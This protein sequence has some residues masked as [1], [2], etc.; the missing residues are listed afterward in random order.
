M[1]HTVEVP[2]SFDGTEPVLPDWA[3]VDRAW[4]SD[5]T[6]LLY[7]VVSD[8]DTVM[9]RSLPDGWE[10]VRVTDLRD[11]ETCLVCREA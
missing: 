11:G 4:V 7:V 5:A 3:G 2:D 8:G 6:G 1:S 10:P 9:F